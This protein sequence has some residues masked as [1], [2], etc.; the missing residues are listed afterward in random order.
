MLIDQ[1]ES[2]RK[3]T[4]NFDDLEWE[5]RLYRFMLENPEDLL[6][7]FHEARYQDGTEILKSKREVASILGWEIP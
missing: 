2:Y 1:L 7:Q 6:L 3:I 4:R 5:I